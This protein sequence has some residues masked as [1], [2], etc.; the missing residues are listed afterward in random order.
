MEKCVKF[1]GW[2]GWM[3]NRSRKSHIVSRLITQMEKFTH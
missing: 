3:K 2:N 1:C